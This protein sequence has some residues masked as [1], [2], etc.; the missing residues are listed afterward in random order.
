MQNVVDNSLLHSLTC[1]V[2]RA[3]PLIVQNSGARG[4]RTTRFPGAKDKGVLG[5][6]NHHF[7]KVLSQPAVL[8]TDSRCLTVGLG[9]AGG[10]AVSLAVYFQILDVGCDDSLL[11]VPDPTIVTCICHSE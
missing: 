5:N 10:Q 3:T 2:V 6:V 11:A 7:F 9:L 8:P 1:W 4:K